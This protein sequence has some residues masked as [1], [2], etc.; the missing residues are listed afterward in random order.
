L[1]VSAQELKA[2]RHRSAFG[3]R[4][5][6]ALGASGSVS[7]RDPTRTVHFAIAKRLEILMRRTDGIPVTTLSAV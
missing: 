4:P 1:G 2:A 7:S 3:A 5:P 6:P